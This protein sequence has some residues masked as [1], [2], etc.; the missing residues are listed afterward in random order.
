MASEDGKTPGN[1]SRPAEEPTRDLGFF[2]RYL[3]A[4]VV[5]CIL[6]GIILG[7]LAPGVATYLDGLAIHIDEAPVVSVP[8]DK[9]TIDGG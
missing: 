7:K 3:T 5:L 1:A 4:W 8:I 6:G 9:T 2:E